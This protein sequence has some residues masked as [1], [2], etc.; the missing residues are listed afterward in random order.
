[1]ALIDHLGLPDVRLVAQSMGGWTCLDYTLRHPERVRA[2]VMA[3]TTGTLESPEL[4]AI[5]AAHQ[6]GEADLFARGI[7]PAAGER[8]AREQPALHHLY[9]QIDGLSF[10]LDKQVVRA[11]LLQMR[12]TPAEAVAA[13]TVPVLCLTGE[14]DIVIPS[15]AVAHL[16]SLIPGARLARVSQAGHSVYFERPAA[17]NEIVDTFLKEAES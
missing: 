12:I 2:L 1:A 16:A 17:F 11:T 14:E 13:L 8:M 3:C 4:R 15:A 6:G 10:A 9:R 5:F 7:H